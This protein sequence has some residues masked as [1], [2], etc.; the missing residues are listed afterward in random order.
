MIAQSNVT[1]MLV[2]KDDDIATSSETRDDLIVGQIG[3]FLAGSTV[4]KT[5]ALSAGERYTIAYKNAKGVVIETPVITYG[6]EASKNADLYSA[7]VQQ[8]SA[9]GYNGTTGSIAVS[10]STNYVMHVFYKDSS[11]TFGGHGEPVKFAAYYSDASAT[12]AEIATGLVENFNKNFAKE[13]PQ[14]LKAEILSADDGTVNAATAGADF[15]HLQFTNGSK[16]VIG[17]LAGVPAKGSDE[18]IDTIVAGDYIRNGT[19]TTVPVYKITAV[20]DGTGTTPN[21]TPL[22]ITLSEAYQGDDAITAVGSTEYSTAAEIAAAD[23][24]VKISALATTSEFQPGVIRYDVTTFTVDLKEE[25]GATDYTNLT[26]AF[27]GSGAYWDVAQ[28]EWFLKGNRG[29]T[30]RV[31]RYPK[32]ITLDATSG[33]TY[34]Y[35]TVEYKTSDAKTIDRNLDAFGTILIATE[36]A[37]AATPHDALKTVLGIS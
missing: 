15:T 20:T 19:A 8:T 9:I 2:G 28:T 17:L 25:F 31:G 27:K 34:D 12:Q 18:K 1:H 33:K 16:Y 3:V 13:N 35:I 26:A 37:S 6:N 23:S 22:I 7:P 21:G 4:A 30:W 10:N 36:D 5:D 14:V 29:E 11:K 32:D 24:G